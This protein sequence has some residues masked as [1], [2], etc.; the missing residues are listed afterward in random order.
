MVE[1]ITAPSKLRYKSLILPSSK[2]ISITFLDSTTLPAV[3][4]C[5]NLLRVYLADSYLFAMV[6]FYFWL[7][8]ME[9]LFRM[10]DFVDISLAFFL[11]STLVF[12]TSEPFDMGFGGT[13]FVFTYLPSWLDSIDERFSVF[14]VLFFWSFIWG[15]YSF[16]TRSS[17]FVYSWSS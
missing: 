2:S 9:A 11:K 4:P 12:D 5:N 10:V 8:V 16:R 3:T 7:V 13:N 6:L 15:V 1:L 17:C 14:D